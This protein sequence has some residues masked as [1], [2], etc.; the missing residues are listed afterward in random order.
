MRTAYLRPLLLWHAISS[1]ICDA[2]DLKCFTGLVYYN[3]GAS[4]AFPTVK[5]KSDKCKIE[6][7]EQKAC[8]WSVKSS[9]RENFKHC[10]IKRGGCTTKDLCPADN[11][12]DPTQDSWCCYS[13][14]CNSEVNVD[15]PP[16]PTTSESDSKSD[17]GLLIPIVTCAVAI[18]VIAILI[19]IGVILWRN[20]VRRT[21]AA[22]PAVVAHVVAE[23]HVPTAVAIEAEAVPVKTHEKMP[24]PTA[25]VVEYR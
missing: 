14:D 2:Q 20:R 10:I 9:K 8:F 4:L 13:G 1:I 21:D 15:P 16:P 7:G 25:P 6:A 19:F 3:C 22:A 5:V 11:S 24:I 23:T 17:D 18:P 12:P